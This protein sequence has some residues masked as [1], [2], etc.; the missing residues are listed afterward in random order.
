[1]IKC[2]LFDMDGTIINSEK[3]TISSKIIEGKK[4]GY[5]VSTEAVIGSF[6]LSREN[7]KR[8]FKNIYG[9]DFPYD[10]LS[11]Y[12]FEYIIN[13]MK[14]NELEA[15]PYAEELIL[16]LKKHNIKICLCTSTNSKRVEVYR[17]L[18]PLLNE[19]DYYITNDMVKQGKPSPDIFIE[20]M[21]QSNCLPSETI[22]VE[23][24][25]SGVVAGLKAKATTI[26]VPDY[27]K[28]D[29]FVYNSPALI[30]N[31]LKEVKEYIIKTNNIKE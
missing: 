23:D 1:M 20:G 17:T 3:Y 22:V 6:G 24:A 8:Y 13:A 28:P 5:D 27:V 12:R 25:I 19:F 29:E 9:E 10:I 15:M 7:S 4:L 16:F 31:S 21:R 18:F 30:M 14:S 11:E 26:M 2:V